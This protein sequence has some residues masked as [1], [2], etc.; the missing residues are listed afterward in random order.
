MR[1]AEEANLR[2]IKFLTSRSDVLTVKCHGTR[3][4]VEA[5][6]SAE[7]NGWRVRVCATRDAGNDAIALLDS[8]DDNDDTPVYVPKSPYRTKWIQDLIRDTIAEMP[9]ATN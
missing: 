4:N 6:H 2:A 8:G 3:F 9:M 5:H 1:I 7:L